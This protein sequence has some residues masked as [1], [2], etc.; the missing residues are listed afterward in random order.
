MS[1]SPEII[2][3]KRTIR[4][5]VRSVIASLSEDF[6]HIASV[7]ASARLTSLAQCQAASYI[8]LY[9][10]L[11][12]E[13]DVTPIAVRCFQRNQSICVPRVDW[14]RK[15]MHPVEIKS[16]DNKTLHTDAHGLRQPTVGTPIPVDMI[17]LVIVPG[18]AFDLNGTRLGR[19]A[20]YYDRFLARLRP[21]ALRVGIA[22]DQQITDPLPVAPHDQRM[23]LIITDKRIITVSS[24]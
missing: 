19:G 2:Q 8:M 14:D 7:S 6:R 10:P 24:S 17:D 9:M 12:D 1:Q 16:L 23:N 4:T 13:V 3:L 5:R 22:F 18:L 11:P 21:S 15:E 20:G